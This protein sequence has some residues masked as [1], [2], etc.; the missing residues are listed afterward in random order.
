MG[1]FNQ[2]K[3]M[4]PI[5]SLNPSSKKAKSKHATQTKQKRGSGPAATELSDEFSTPKC[6]V[7]NGSHSNC[8]DCMALTKKLLNSEA[9]RL[10]MTL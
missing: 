2:V 1:K 5:V 8:N 3:S 7:E 9:E 6:D 4:S 10:E